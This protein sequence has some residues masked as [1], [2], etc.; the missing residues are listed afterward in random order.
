MNQT[1]ERGRG[2]S[3]DGPLHTPKAQPLTG[4]C[5]RA[6]SAITRDSATHAPGGIFIVLLTSRRLYRRSELSSNGEKSASGRRAANE[7]GR[8]QAGRWAGQ[9][10]GVH[11]LSEHLAGPMESNCGVVRRES[12]L[13]RQGPDRSFFQVGA[14]QYG[15][16][17]RFELADRFRKAFDRR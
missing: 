5:I 8:E 3:S 11:N 4:R 2:T 9:A 13:T 10:T 17:T 7:A 15:R 6:D 14:A 16:V 1:S 12:K